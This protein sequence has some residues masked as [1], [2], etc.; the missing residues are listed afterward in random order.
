MLGESGL[1]TV[2][3]RSVLLVFAVVLVYG[4]VLRF[5]GAVWLL[6]RPTARPMWPWPFEARLGSFGCCGGGPCDLS[7]LF[8]TVASVG[9]V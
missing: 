9:V 2:R 1:G 4:A 6:L 7:T 5:L 8:V 3:V